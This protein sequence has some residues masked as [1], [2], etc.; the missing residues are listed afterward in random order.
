M[1]VSG[2][3]S[4]EHSREPM[5][6]GL[7]TYWRR[8]RLSD[9]AYRR[10]YSGGMLS[11][12]PKKYRKLSFADAQAIRAAREQNPAL[13]LTDL[14]GKFGTTPMSSTRVLRGEVHRKEKERKLTPQEVQ[15]LRYLAGTG[16][17][18]QEEVSKRYGI[19][20]G[21]VSRIVNRELYASRPVHRY[22]L[23]RF[24]TPRAKLHTHTRTIRTIGPNPLESQALLT[25]LIKSLSRWEREGPP[26]G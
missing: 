9:K 13:S 10:R 15:E 20:Q 8:P 22:E 18:T 25:K 19:S 2:G 16:D 4:G 24:A 26:G 11:K 12:K 5:K 23:A 21:E 6:A 17:L 14:A 3:T 1:P 7:P